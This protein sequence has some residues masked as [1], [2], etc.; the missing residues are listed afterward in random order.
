[1]Y[2]ILPACHKLNAATTELRSIICIMPPTIHAGVADIVF[3][4]GGDAI[5]ETAFELAASVHE[6]HVRAHVS[7]TL[8]APDWARLAKVNCLQ[9]NKGH[10]RSFCTRSTYVAYNV[11]ALL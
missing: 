1:M 11:C 5:A 4:G 2:H 9:A 3:R 10:Q 6:L 7:L 8:T